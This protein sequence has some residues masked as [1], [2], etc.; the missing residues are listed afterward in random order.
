MTIQAYILL[1]DFEVPGDPALIKG[2]VVYRCIQGTYGVV[3]YDSRMTGKPHIAITLD[4]DGGY[5]FVVVP[6]SILAAV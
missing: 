3:T 1:E 6:A 5:P 4:P 2:T